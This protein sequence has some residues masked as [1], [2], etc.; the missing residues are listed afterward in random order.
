MG[1]VS[2]IRGDQ[3]M[4]PSAL[5]RGG[6]SRGPFFLASDLPDDDA[7]RGRIL[8]AAM[9]TQHPLE[10]DGVGGGHPLTSK[11]GIVGP[12]AL[13]GVDLDFTFA[14]LQPGKTTV[15]TT[16]NCGNMLAAVVPFAVERGLITPESDLTSVVVITTNTGLKSRIT[17]QTPVTA[18]GRAVAY[19][20]D[21]EISGVPGTGAPIRISFLDTEGSIA[22]S[23]LP[24]GSARDTFELASGRTI[25]VTC[26]DNGQPMV[27]MRAAD[28]GVSGAESVAELEADEG[29]K[30]LIEEI[31]LVAGE[32]MGLGD[33]TD[34]SYPKMTILS[35]PLAGGDIST[36]SLIPHA[37]HTSIGVLAA[38]TVAT[39]ALME[40]SVASDYAPA[41]AD[42]Y[43]VEHPSGIFDVSFDY[44]DANR[45]SYGIIRT[46]R[47]IM[48]GLIA[49]PSSVYSLGEVSS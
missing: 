18:A 25:D 40:G 30:A 1:H 33:V 38:V 9:G 2:K 11:A 19:A 16:A 15:Q 5:M 34:L 36:R 28:V 47:L 31:R 37:V 44:D 14:Q 26:L 45:V 29:V 49:V 22:G 7:A 21:A 46:A 32:R 39:A 13:D 10:I 24:T 23:L 43:R 48:D 6:T 12:S 41:A 4:I 3:V 27:V 42:Q 17:V 35:A 20:G 8:V